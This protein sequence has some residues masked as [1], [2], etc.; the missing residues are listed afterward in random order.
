MNY[1]ELL[2]AIAEKA[3]TSVVMKSELKTLGGKV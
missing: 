2:K 3:E 1:I